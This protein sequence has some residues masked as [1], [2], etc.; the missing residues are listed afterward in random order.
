MTNGPRP[1]TWKAYGA[2][3]ALADADRDGLLRRTSDSDPETETAAREI[4]ARVRTEGDAALHAFA[5]EFDGVKLDRLDVPRDRWETAW[6]GLPSTVRDA[7]ERAARNIERFHRA[8]LPA[9]VS[10]EVEPGIWLER[11]AQPVRR[12]GVYAP[13]GRAAYPSSV[14]MGVVPARVAGVAEVVVCS[15]PG[16]DGDPPDAVLAAALLGGADRVFAVGG[17]GAV[18]A[19]AFGTE[20]VDAVDVIVGPGNRFVNEAKRLVAGTVRI[21]SPA[22]PS[23][24]LLLIDGSATPERVAQ[25]LVAQAEHDPDAAAGVVCLADRD[26]DGPELAAAV[27]EATGRAVATAERA[28]VVRAALAENGFLL[29]TTSR[30]AAT[31][32]ANDYAAEHLS[33]VLENGEDVVDSVTNAG[34]IFV[35]PH[36]SVAFGDYLTGANHVL[37]TGGRARSY[38]GLSVDAFLRTHTVQRLDG[39]GARALAEATSVLA[40]AEGLPGH[41]AAARAAGAAR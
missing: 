28:D 41:A 11:R 14:L 37:P 9:A 40:D 26:A 27:A 31:R 23:E 6:A 25:E 34:T 19:M 3:E 22:G 12:A 4:V 21:D 30:E 1:L 10:L 29:W 24:I 7:L 39:D 20:T 18:G 38:S 13:G 8:Q 15:P 35:G 2:L 32:F 5:R 36:S 17:A 16:P 33:V